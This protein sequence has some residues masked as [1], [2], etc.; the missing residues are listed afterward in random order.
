[1]ETGWTSTKHNMACY[2]VYIIKNFTKTWLIIGELSEVEQWCRKRILWDRCWWERGLDYP[3]TN[4]KPPARRVSSVHKQ[5][6]PYTFPRYVFAPLPCWPSSQWH[7]QILA[8]DLTFILSQS[9]V[10][11]SSSRVAKASHV[12]PLNGRTS[13]N[14]RAETF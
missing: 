11:S 1:M 9:S 4:N 10:S 12:R 13:A 3:A 2:A 8:S 5:C 6:T 7:R 14:H